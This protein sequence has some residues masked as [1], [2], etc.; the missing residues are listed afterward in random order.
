MSVSPLDY[1]SSLWYVVHIINKDNDMATFD[2]QT[3]QKWDKK[4][5]VLYIKW[6]LEKSWL[7]EM[8]EKQKERLEQM[9]AKL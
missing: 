5:S 3:L 2:L 1:Q 4:R 7:L 6:S 8:R 9:P